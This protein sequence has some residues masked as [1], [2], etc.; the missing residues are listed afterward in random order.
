MQPGTSTESKNKTIQLHY[1]K[2]RLKKIKEEQAIEIKEDRHLST[3][4]GRRDD[5]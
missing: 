3:R 4:R 1:S 2:E 5:L